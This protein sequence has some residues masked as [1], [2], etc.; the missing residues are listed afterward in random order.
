MP[1]KLELYFGTGICLKNYYDGEI[2]DSTK[3]PL[4]D[5]PVT[6]FDEPTDTLILQQGEEVYEQERLA[7]KKVFVTPNGETVLDFG[8]NMTGYVELF[9]NANVGDCVDLSFAEV[10]DKDG[11]FY[12][13]NYR[14]AKAQYHYICKDLA[15]I[16]YFLWFSIYPHQ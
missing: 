10:M 14:G 13:E 5:Q 3:A 15:S 4:L 6:M 12:T 11:N 1:T 16:T 9:V 2:Y 8:Q 7:V